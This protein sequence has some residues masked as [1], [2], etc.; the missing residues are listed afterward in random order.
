MNVEETAS[1][2]QPWLAAAIEE[3]ER[4]R[5]LADSHDRPPLRRPVL[6]SHIFF[7][8]DID[9]AG[10]R[11]GRG[12]IA[13]QSRIPPGFRPDPSTPGCFI[14][15]PRY[16]R[17]RHLVFERIRTRDRGNFDF[18]R[19]DKMRLESDVCINLGDTIQREKKRVRCL[20]RSRG[21]RCQ[22]RGPRYLLDA[23]YSAS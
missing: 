1:R 16:A 17:A 21:R 5:R 9:N 4:R 11:G 10:E 18:V 3:S 2:P 8:H 6:F 7:W 15:G 20:P 22:K 14:F 23:A 12:S 13:I 19:S